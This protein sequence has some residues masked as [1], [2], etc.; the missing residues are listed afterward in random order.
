MRKQ[1]VLEL[2]D[3]FPSD[4]L[5]NDRLMHELYLRIKLER[6]EA[7]VAAGQVVSHDDAVRRSQGWFK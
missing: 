4:E 6:A 5:D 7:A 1:E 2:L 3:E